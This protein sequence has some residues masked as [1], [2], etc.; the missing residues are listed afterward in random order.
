MTEQ[1]VTQKAN[2]AAPLP[3][4]NPAQPAAEPAKH[5]ELSAPLSDGIKSFR[6]GVT[7]AKANLCDAQHAL[8]QA[9][10]KVEECQRA[11]AVAEAKL[12]GA[13]LQTVFSTG[14]TQGNWSVTPD[15]TGIIR[16]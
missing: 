12:E 4:S 3:L 7:L 16:G 5:H 10:A 13:S 15:G 8:Q 6:V 1:N 14:E 2:G 9:Q 11:L